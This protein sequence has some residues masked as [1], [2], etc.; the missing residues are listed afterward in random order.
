VVFAVLA[1]LSRYEGLLAVGVIGLALLVRKRWRLATLMGACA[2]LPHVVLGLISVRQGWFWLP[3]PV[4]LKGNLPPE[5]A[6]PLVASFLNHVAESVTGSGLRVVHLTGVALLFALYRFSEG[7]RGYDPLQWTAG[8]F[9]ATAFLHLVFARAGWFYRYEAY[10]VVLG[11]VTIAPTLFEF[12]RHFPRNLR[13]GPGEIAG[14]A[15]LALLAATGH[16]FWDAGY[17][18]LRVTPLTTH[19]IYDCNYQVGEFVSRYYSGAPLAVND[20]GAVSYIADFHLTDFH[21]LADMAV[22]RALLQGTFNSQA[23]DEIARWRG[24]RVAIVDDNYLASYGGTPR[25]WLLAGR[26][27][28]GRRVTLA[29]PAISFYALDP[30]ARAR[31][32][33]NLRDFSPRLPPDVEQLGPYRETANIF[34]APDSR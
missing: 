28:F 12:L 20:I 33:A 27:H 8:I 30:E 19:N 22:A 16:L 14:L 1:S 18:A 23:M 9:G 26:W 24:A 7:K 29:Y 6:R 17:R 2:L 25:Q 21:G 4:M 10:L 13:L 3:N 31:L 15:A 11:L 5:G 32:V 34:P